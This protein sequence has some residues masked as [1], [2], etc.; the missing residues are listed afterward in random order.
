[1]ASCYSSPSARAFKPRAQGL[2]VGVGAHLLSLISSHARAEDVV[3][4]VLAEDQHWSQ[5]HLPL[6]GVLRQGLHALDMLFLCSFKKRL[7]CNS[8]PRV[9]YVCVRPMMAAVSVNH[10]L[11]I[12][13]GAEAT[14]QGHPRDDTNFIQ[15]T[16]GFR[17]QGEGRGGRGKER[18]GE[19]RGR[20]GNRTHRSQ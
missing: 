15:E 1:M 3:L 20:E 19:E 16:Q 5:R 18:G 9:S 4:T 7:V 8:K 11:R 17:E 13:G 12:D 14:T 10:E 6:L 2:G